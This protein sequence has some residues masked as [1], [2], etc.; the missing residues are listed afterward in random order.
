MYTKYGELSSYQLI[1]MYAIPYYC[2][3]YA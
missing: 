2:A 3:K 1:W